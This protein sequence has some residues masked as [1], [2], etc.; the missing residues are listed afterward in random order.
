M[1]NRRLKL[2]LICGLLSVSLCACNKKEA[3]EEPTTQEEVQ[4]AV[5]LSGV[6][7][8]QVL[9]TETLIDY[10]NTL[11][12]I[13]DVNAV[14]CYTETE[15][16]VTE[17]T[18]QEGVHTITIVYATA[19]GTNGEV[20]LVYEAGPGEVAEEPTEDTEEVTDESDEEVIQ[21]VSIPIEGR[22][23]LSV[24]DGTTT[25][26]EEE[27]STSETLE[28]G[29][30]INVTDVEATLSM[31][32]PLTTMMEREVSNKYKVSDTYYE[33]YYDDSNYVATIGYN[34]YNQD[35][36]V[37]FEVNS[38][39]SNDKLYFGV[40]LSE[41]AV[42]D[43]ELFNDEVNAVFDTIEDYYTY[44]FTYD[45]KII[46]DTEDET[47]EESTE[48]DETVQTDKEALIEDKLTALV[49]QSYREAHPELYIWPENPIKYSRWDYRITDSTSFKSN[50]TLEDGTVIPEAQQQQDGY[51]YDLGGN[52]FA[53]GSNKNNGSV[54]KA[55]PVVEEQEE[56]YVLAGLRKFKIIEYPGMNIKI[57]YENSSDIS[58]KL[59][60]NGSIYYVKSIPT[61]D[62][63]KY[64][65][66]DYYGNNP[67]NMEVVL[68]E[69]VEIGSGNLKTTVQC[70]T[71]QF[72]DSTG[73]TVERAYMYGINCT[74]S[75]LIVVGDSQPTRGNETLSKIVNNCIEP[76]ELD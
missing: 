66:T 6:T 73:A 57:D 69:A 49:G 21:E 75:Y 71:L 41:D 48:S 9:N 4:Q 32:D 50:I 15:S 11:A 37:Y 31:Y 16:N 13:T 2:L 30:L 68:G 70:R 74:D 1:K 18:L 17:V 34:V 65:T 36:V 27:F 76:V 52:T 10:A 61:A 59:E 47:E 20:S 3:V 56:A 28:V 22:I 5:N 26:T 35:G 44:E 38:V 7:A 12:G 46:E 14:S 33:Y 42:T 43:D 19:S 24:T 58:V 29:A 39:N 55:E 54:S 51:Q 67:T 23:K 8:G 53:S 25:M 64:S 40:K 45:P 72:T 60:N 63:T 62:W